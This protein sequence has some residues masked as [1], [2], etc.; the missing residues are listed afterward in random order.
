MS[1][2]NVLFDYQTI[3][4]YTYYVDTKDVLSDSWTLGGTG[5][6][7]DGGIDTFSAPANVVTKRYYRIRGTYP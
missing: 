5:T 7:G 4:G 6:P 3:S 2:T 1:G